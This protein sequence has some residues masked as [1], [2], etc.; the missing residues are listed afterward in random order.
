[1]HVGGSHARVERLRHGAV[2]Q[3]RGAARQ[4]QALDFV[5]VLDHAA[6]GGDGRGADNRQVRIRSANAFRENELHVLVETDSS[7]HKAA[8]PQAFGQGDEGALVLLPYQNFRV[9]TQRAGGQQLAGASLLKR[10]AHQKRLGA[11]R[12]HQGPQ[13]LAAV[14]AQIGEVDG[15]TGAVGEND[16]IDFR[17]RHQRFCLLD[18]RLS[19]GNGEWP[20]LTGEHGQC[21]DG[22]R[23]SRAVRARTLRAG[24]CG[25]GRRH[26]RTQKIPPC[27]RCLRSHEP[28]RSAHFSIRGGGEELPKGKARLGVR[29][30]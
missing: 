8:V 9:F 24:D 7:R 3:Q 23:Q 28:P 11:R 29:A 16:G 2:D 26:A 27:Q 21:C 15:G 14:K 25:S 20:D 18:A 10:R 5:R 22:P 13:A 19:L 4:A 12:Q 17:G 30:V 1:M 6:A